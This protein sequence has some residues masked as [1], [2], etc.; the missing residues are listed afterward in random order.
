MVKIVHIPITFLI[1]TAIRKIL[2]NTAIRK[3]ES[4]EESTTKN[5][6]ISS[7]LNLNFIVIPS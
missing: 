4:K 7:L 6:V 1:N 2:I 5:K 3:I